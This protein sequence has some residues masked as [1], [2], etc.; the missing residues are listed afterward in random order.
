MIDEVH[1]SLP[2]GVLGRI[3]HAVKVRRDVNR[4]FEYRRLQID[5]LFG[6]PGENAA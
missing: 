2:F 1:Y 5:A 3:V 6:Q 4:I